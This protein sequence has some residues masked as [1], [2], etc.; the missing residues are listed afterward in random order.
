LLKASTIA[1][2]SVTPEDKKQRTQKEGFQEVRR[3]K[4]HSSSEAARTSKKPVVTAAPAAVNATP[5]AVPTRNFFAPP[6]AAKFAGTEEI[7]QEEVTPG[8]TC[9][10]PPIVITAATNLL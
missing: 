7:L 2:K 3:R 6:R 10:P 5:Q 4:R 1:G 9:R 8:K